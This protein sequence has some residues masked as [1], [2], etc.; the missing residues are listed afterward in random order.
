MIPTVDDCFRA[1]AEYGMLDNIRDHSILVARVTALLVENIQPEG[2]PLSMGRAVAGALLHDIG[3][4]ACLDTDEDHAEKGR[5]I[6]LALGMDEIA[7]IVAQHVL[8]RVK[9]TTDFTEEEIVYYADKRV[10]HDQVVSL[11][12][13]LTYIL[14]RYG[15]NN[16][17]RHQ[18]IL[19]NFSR[20]K[21]L[22][23]RIFARL[24]FDS[25]EVASRLA[26]RRDALIGG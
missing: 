3:K 21:A 20:C 8:L 25:E 18:A 16:P 9:A 13:R 1:M 12:E 15:R 23:T 17:A 22:E 4:T 14:D 24:P 7:E 2:A 11:E 10:N 26:E 5:Q 6:C 19:L